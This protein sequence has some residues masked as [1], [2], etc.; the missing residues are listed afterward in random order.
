MEH[1]TDGLPIRVLALMEAS[2]VTGPAK[3]LI[4]LAQQARASQAEVSPVQF[5]ICTFLRGRGT[6]TNAFIKRVECAGLDLHPIAERFAF[7][8]RI[9]PQIRAVVQTV[10]PHLIQSHSCKSHFLVRFTGMHRDCRWV[11]FHHGYTC[12]DVKNRLY[13]QL[14]RWSLRAADRVITVCAP[15]ASHLRKIGVPPDRI[16][17]QHNSVKPFTPATPRLVMQLRDKIGLPPDAVAILCVG[18][19]SREKAQ[20]DLLEAL[21]RL[22]RNGFDRKFAVVIVGDGPERDRIRRRAKQLG[23][24]DLM[25][26]VGQQSD[27]IPFFTM[28]ELMVLPSHSEGSPNVL[29][30]AMAAGLPSIA[31]RVGGVPE[32]VRDGESALLVPADDP[33][34]L[35]NAIRRALSDLALR[36]RLGSNAR[37]I[38]RHY[39]PEAYCKSM[40]EI[41]SQLVAKQA[42]ACESCS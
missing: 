28:A 27:V 29:L 25:F 5:S 8:A 15:F 2:S 42:A 23:I 9:I 30:E 31:T 22:R 39:A 17:I 35:A 21:G 6:E 4:A 18:R 7:D 34:A 36:K 37:D 3:N 11:A 38:A 40:I 16:I 13:N 41:Y 14:D 24:S 26:M 1:M 19:L 12:T 10:R 32:L 33:E 20:I